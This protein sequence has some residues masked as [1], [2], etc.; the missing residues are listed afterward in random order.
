MI[1]WVIRFAVITCLL[2][3]AGTI[4][5]ISHINGKQKDEKRMQNEKKMESTTSNLKPDSE[6]IK[7]KPANSTLAAKPVV[8][9]KKEYPASKTLFQEK[10][11]E[12]EISRT[13]TAKAATPEATRK[14]EKQSRLK[15]EEE[16]KLFTS[17][18]LQQL[19]NRINKAKEENSINSNCVQ[20]Y[21]TTKGN[22]KR[23]ISQVE[24]Y[25]KSK[26]F[27]IAGREVIEKEVKGIKITPNAGCIRITI[28]TF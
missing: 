26:R 20:I 27:A 22:Y 18:E 12:K 2:G 28:G 7:P 5:I 10:E 8:V 13:P 11:I 14:A 16:E 15:N 3:L 17:E 24:T 25:L 4:A 9:E 21:S 1:K 6:V 19:V 23:T